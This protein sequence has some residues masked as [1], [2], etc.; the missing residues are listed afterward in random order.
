MQMI[1]VSTFVLPVISANPRPRAKQIHA[2]R[3]IKS[4]SI[5]QTY[6][7]LPILSSDIFHYSS[8]REFNLTTYT[9]S[10]I[11]WKRGGWVCYQTLFLMKKLWAAQLNVVAIMGGFRCQ[12]KISKCQQ[13]GITIICYI[14]LITS[15]ILNRRTTLWRSLVVLRVKKMQRPLFW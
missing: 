3:Q 1:V 7:L 6:S 11:C 8:K 2:S 12:N 14:F 15:T 4:R 9:Y 5:C 10:N 13:S